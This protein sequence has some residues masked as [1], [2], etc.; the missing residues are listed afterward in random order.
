VRAIPAL[1]S[2]IVATTVGCAFAPSSEVAQDGVW[3]QT[4]VIEELRI[5]VESGAAEYMFGR[6]TSMTVASNGTMYVVDGQIPIIRA[7]DRAGVFV[8]DVGGRGQGPGEYQTVLAT[9]MLPG[10]E[11]AVW[12]DLSGRL[13]FYSADGE[14]LRSFS[15]AIESHMVRTPAERPLLG[16]DTDGHLYLLADEVQDVTVSNVEL[17]LH[18]YSPAGD[19]LAT[20]T[21]PSAE[22]QGRPFILGPEGNL[23]PFS[24]MNVYAW[25]PLGYLVVGRNNSYSIELRRPDGTVQLSRDLPQLRVGSEERSEW[26]AFRDRLIRHNRELGG[27][28]DPSPVPGTKPFFRDLLPAEDGR[29]WVHRYVAAEKRAGTAPH[30]DP[31]R[32]VLTWREPNLYDVFEPDGTFLGETVFPNGFRPLVI[33][34]DRVWGIHTDDGGVQQVIRMRVMTTADSDGAPRASSAE[35]P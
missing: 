32:P 4:S 16:T 21:V 11:L 3:H 26:S 7:F 28:V 12:D 17:I 5:G 29:I 22:M 30:P 10:D 23:M 33:R 6:V 27:G 34:G 2:A 20:V 8:G 35:Y 24:V 19:E 13:S 31:E 18:K 9:A 15:P 14:Y 25:S 1:L